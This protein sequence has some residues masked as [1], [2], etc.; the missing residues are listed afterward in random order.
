MA[1]ARSLRDTPYGISRDH[2]PEIAK[3]RQKLWPQFK[4]ARSDPANRAGIGYPAK[5]IVNGE[6]V[7]DMFPDWDSIMRGSRIS[8]QYQ[9]GEQ[10]REPA[11]IPVSMQPLSSLGKNDG[12]NRAPTL[13]V[14]PGISSDTSAQNYNVPHEYMDLDTQDPNNTNSPQSPESERNSPS[15]ISERQIGNRSFSVPTRFTV[16]PVVNDQFRIDDTPNPFREHGPPLQSDLTSSPRSLADNLIRASKFEAPGTATSTSARTNGQYGS[17]Y[18]D[19]TPS[20]SSR[21]NDRE[22]SSARPNSTQSD[23]A[24]RK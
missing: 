1:N 12:I 19:H 17:T 14:I 22:T 16:P 15:I 2:P 21:E 13:P 10:T 7:C 9:Q 24:S 8:I 5:L 4:A 23:D 6:V 20:R 18:R 3:A 11:S